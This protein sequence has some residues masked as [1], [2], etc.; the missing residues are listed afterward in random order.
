MVKKLLLSPL[1]ILVFAQLTY[2]QP[3]SV[4]NGSNALFVQ[5]MFDILDVEEISSL[6][7]TIRTNPYV[8]LVRLD[9]YSKRFFLLTKN[10]SSLDEEQLKSWFGEY[11]N[12]IKCIQIG[13]HGIDQ[14]APFPFINCP[15]N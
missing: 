11:S 13:V 4:S 10:I 6:E 3:A 15:N 7:A 14:V 8:Q 12:A 2:A 9:Q 5:G 1:L